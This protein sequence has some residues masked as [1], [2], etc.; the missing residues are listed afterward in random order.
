VR[1]DGRLKHF[2]ISIISTLLKTWDVGNWS[3]KLILIPSVYTVYSRICLKCCWLFT[4]KNS[5]ENMYS[6][7]RV[8]VCNPLSRLLH[9]FLGL[10]TAI[11]ITVFF[12]KVNIILLLH[13]LPP[14]NYS[15]LH[16][17]MKIDKINWFE[18]VSVDCMTQI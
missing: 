12:C 15:M 3:V 7:G 17:R 2:Y 18:G 6:H 1:L 16:Y 10:T 14:K 13:E 4:V 8:R 9:E 5:N 11:N